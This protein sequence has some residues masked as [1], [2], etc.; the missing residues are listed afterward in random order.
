MHTKYMSYSKTRVRSLQLLLVICGSLLA[1]QALAK[2]PNNKDIIADLKKALT[3][4]T[5]STASSTPTS[6][7]RYIDQVEAIL[8]QGRD[9]ELEQYLT[10]LKATIPPS[11]S[12]AASLVEQ[13]LTNVRAKIAEAAAKQESA[14]DAIEADFIAKFSAKAPAADFDN[15]LKRL[16]ALPVLGPYNPNS[17]KVEMLRNFITRWQ[18]YLLQSAKGN[19]EQAAQALN[20]LVQQ[21]S[22]LPI[23]PRSHLASLLSETSG[24][25]GAREEAIEARLAALRKQLVT[26]IDSAR[27]AADFDAILVELRKAVQ[28]DGIAVRNS[29]FGNELDNLRKFATRWQDYFSQMEAGNVQNAQNILRELSTTTNNNYD[30]IYPRSQILARLNG[31]PVHASSASPA[32]RPEPLIPPA[33]LTI[34]KLDQLY[35]QIQARRSANI[36][37]PAGMEDVPAELG[38]LRTSL[39]FLFSGTPEAVLID[40]RSPKDM[41]GRLG[42]Y[43]DAFGTVKRE[44]MMRALREYLEAPSSVPPLKDDTFDTYS[45]RL[46]AYGRNQK[47]WYLIYRVLLARKNFP[48]GTSGSN[49]DLNGYKMFIAGLQQESAGLWSMAV[50]SYFNALNAGSPNLPVAEIGERLRR[51]KAEHPEEYAKTPY[52]LYMSETSSSPGQSPSNYPPAGFYSLPASKEQKPVPEA[53]PAN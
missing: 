23:I 32:N 4:P 41:P 48:P 51:I 5:V 13:L 36:A 30:A 15:L 19:T 52:T 17:Q 27:G 10:Q 45:K 28:F 46:I 50:H 35:Q 31:N 2:T 22:R 43:A 33:E 38:Y 9:T 25:A 14:Y 29:N 24:R 26:V 39:A 8:A 42:D 21:S 44:I 1:G 34:E 49:T 40:S 53:Q 20:E 7:A 18:D 3:E 11:N 6:S 37:L 16:A 12:K 47:D